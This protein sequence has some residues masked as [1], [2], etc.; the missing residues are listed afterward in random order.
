MVP[1]VART[2]ETRSAPAETGLMIPTRMPAREAWTVGV[3][4]PAAGTG[5]RMGGVRKPFLEL[6]GEPLLLRSLRP[7]LEH[8]R[9]EAMAIALGEQD[10][11]DPPSWLAG[12]DPR[13]R[14]VL[15]GSTRG[16]SVRAALEALPASVDVVA[17][18]DAARPLVTREIIER[19]LQEV[20]PGRGVVAGWPAVDTL[21]EVDH[22]GRIVG[23][24]ARDRIWHAQTP[25]VFPRDMILEAYREAA[26]SG[27]VDTDDAALVERIGGEV[28]MVLGSASNLKITCPADLVLAEALLRGR[29][30]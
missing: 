9:V 4:I 7:F 6:D 17:V 28:V 16:E 11:L 15:G 8:P 5:S 21:K 12:A 19:C 22:G 30:G 2:R 26:R 10:F 3:A 23:T 1:A 24:P 18:H 13:I 29:T 27:M 14:L 20:G 25:Q